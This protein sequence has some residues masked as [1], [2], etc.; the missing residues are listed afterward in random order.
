MANS[1]KFFQKDGTIL[2]Q[3][4][5][6][7]D[8]IF[9][10]SLPHDSGKHNIYAIDVC[11][12]EVVLEPASLMVNS[13]SD[14]PS[15]QT[16]RSRSVRPTMSEQGETNSVLTEKSRSA[17]LGSLS[18]IKSD[19]L[20]KRLQFSTKSNNI[21]G[22]IDNIKQSNPNEFGYSNHLEHSNNKR[23]N[24]VSAVTI[25][26][27]RNI[28]L[29]NIRNHSRQVLPSEV[30]YQNSTDS[31]KVKVDHSPMALDT[32][33]VNPF[34]ASLSTVVDKV[35]PGPSTETKSIQL[36][37]SHFKPSK[38][39]PSHSQQY[40]V[41]PTHFEQAKLR[42]S[43]SKISKVRP[44][45][46]N[47]T[48][49]PQLRLSTSQQYEVRPSHSRPNWHTTDASNGYE[50]DIS[51]MSDISNT[52]ELMFNAAPCI[53]EE[54]D[55]AYAYDTHYGEFVDSKEYET[56]DKPSVYSNEYIN[57]LKSDYD[58][59]N[60]I[61]ETS[62]HDYGTVVQKLPKFPNDLVFDG[63]QDWETFHTNFKFLLNGCGDN[64]PLASLLVSCLKGQALDMARI[65]SKQNERLGLPTLT[66]TALCQL[67]ATNYYR[68]ED[69]SGKLKAF[70]SAVQE[71]GE[72]HIMYRN[73]LS[74]LYM[75]A[76]PTAPEDHHEANVHAM[77]LLGMKENSKSR[78]WA[79][80]DK[81]SKELATI[82]D[83][84]DSM[85][86]NI[87][88]SCIDKQNSHGITPSDDCY[89]VQ[90][91]KLQVRKAQDHQHKSKYADFHGR[92]LK[93]FEDHQRSLNPVKDRYNGRRDPKLCGLR[94]YRGN[95][96]LPPR[97]FFA[98][99]PH[100]RQSYEPEDFSQSYDL[101]FS[102][103]GCGSNLHGVDECPVLS[104]ITNTVQ[105]TVQNTLD[106]NYESIHSTQ[107]PLN[108]LGPRLPAHR[109]PTQ[110]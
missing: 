54:Q 109:G 99:K 46:A 28:D 86:A 38:V 105:D 20:D 1:G 33:K 41:R 29:Q 26:K 94:Q 71:D 5:E 104:T 12:T 52:E 90:Y 48:M 101:D 21:A 87:L 34:G 35:R 80:K 69:T 53:E 2:G 14:G 83:D 6:Y 96:F 74:L 103:D 24:Y 30:V 82:L 3:N 36:R 63:T 65:F 60:Q 11:D 59:H 106:K 25:L 42:P 61:N 68:V 39:R 72:S 19:K 56:T 110:G 76:F 44:S 9:S 47:D 89:V 49:C 92:T 81:T 43:H 78:I 16:D 84:H 95:N 70:F 85:M 27:Q 75:D 50:T 97:Y 93:E 77:F 91:P 31:G 40:K 67:M 73:R 7:N 37:P 58:S 98:S 108:S 107:Q 32:K 45:L 23:N 100:R 4:C 10:K 62:N 79:A 13:V 102:C 55:I 64:L 8:G 17:R 66:Y 15:G 57:K 88:N 51:D 18:E 22:N